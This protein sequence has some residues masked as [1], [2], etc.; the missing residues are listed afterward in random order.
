MRSTLLLALCSAVSLVACSPDET[1][2][3]GGGGSGG[4]PGTGGTGGG[5]PPT[6]LIAAPVTRYDYVFDATLLS[7]DTKITFD[8]QAPGGDCVDLESLPLPSGQVTW[9]TE[10]AISA[11]AEN[12]VLHACGAGVAE[13]PLEVRAPTVFPEKKFY[14][15][16]VGYSVKT[17]MDG[18]DFSYLLSWVGGC[19]SFGPCDDDPGTLA[20]MHF[21]IVHPPGAPVLCA[22][23][24]TPGETSTRCDIEGTLAPTYSGVAWASDPL[25][26]KKPFMTAGGVDWVFYEVPSGQLMASLDEA[27]MTDFFG[28]L[29]GLFG[30]FPYG[31]ELRF[32]GG[33]TAWL[34]FEHPANIVLHEELASLPTS[35]YDTL[36]HVTMHEIVHQWAGDRT[37]IASAP[38]FVWKEATAEY[39]PYV[40]EDEKLPA[41]AGAASREYWD[42]VS[43]QA[44]HYPR[45]TDDPM[46]HVS[47]FYGDVYGPGPM[48][49]YIQLE[50]LLGREVVLA[51][52]QAF[53]KEPGARSVDELRLAMEE[54]S[55]KDLKPYF[56]VWVFGAGAPEWPT[57]KIEASQDA[58]GEVTVTVTQQ[59][60][61][62]KL[63][64][65]VVEVD[66]AG[67]TQTVTAK[68]DFGIAPQSASATAKVM[69]PE[70]VMGTALDPRNRLVAR[71]AA[72]ALVQPE[73]RPVW[74]F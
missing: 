45:P 66:V 70:P 34:G 59:N 44:Q 32:A 67:A 54:A 51:G 36:T 1:G 46:P 25:W 11:T 24:L 52:L 42:S 63:Y 38:D 74:I 2:S 71:E 43:L 56:D 21:E 13:G 3:P 37:T 27:T 22:G 47:K 40:Y 14:G 15:L 12:G 7:A 64:G 23:V 39:I 73:P 55:G 69:L 68:I 8:V 19:D 50:A 53:L 18:G 5:A 72:A 35:Y 30:P 9:N 60:A 29:T 57:L 33:P 31:D 62:G 61:S 28:W 4:S 26:Q 16:D 58:N 10:A 20:E 41:N 65:C 49:L 6:G 17:D 48:V